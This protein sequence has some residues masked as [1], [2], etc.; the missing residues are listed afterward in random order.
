PPRRMFE[1]EVAT[2]KEL[3]LDRQPAPRQR[4]RSRPPPRTI[5]RTEPPWHQLASA[6][7]RLT[8]PSVA[9]PTTRLDPGQGSHCLSC[10][11]GAATPPVLGT[12]GGRSGFVG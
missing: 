8:G 3:D 1:H 7:R 6:T 10:A 4:T 9:K 12:T 5:P 2:G 11:G